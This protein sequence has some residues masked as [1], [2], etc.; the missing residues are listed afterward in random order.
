MQFRSVYGQQG[1]SLIELSV[2]TAIYSMGL[3]SL[4]L[5]MLFAL[6]GTAGARLDTAAVVHA[7]SLA[8]LIAMNSDAVGHYVYPTEPA[9]GACDAGSPCTSEQ[10]ATWNFMTW[11]DRVVADLPD[12]DGLLCRDSSPDDGDAT[13]PACDGGGGPVVKVFWRAPA[14]SGAEPTE[15]HRQVSR[16]PLP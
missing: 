15:P 7:A 4:S 9:A 16:L 13:D 2:A 6:H 12:G 14:D 11:R 5:L 3:G 1:F 10:M 8:E